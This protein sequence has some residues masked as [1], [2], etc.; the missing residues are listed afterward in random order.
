MDFLIKMKLLLLSKENIQL[1]KGEAEALLGKGKLIGNILL[2]NTEKKTGR[3]AY[4][5][6][7]CRV[8]FTANRKNIEKKIKRCKWSR[9]VKGSFALEFIK[10]NKKSNSL[11]RKYGGMVYDLLKAKSKPKVDLE[12]PGTKLVFA[13]IKNKIYACVEEF[14]N[15]EDFNARKSQNRPENLPISLS[16]KLARACV[17]LTGSNTSV[18]DPFCGIGGFLIEAGL[19]GLKAIGSDIDMKMTNASKRNLEF[20]KIKNFEIFQQDA[21]KINKKYCYIVTDLPYGRNARIIGDV[22]NKFL[23]NLKNI[24]KKRAVVMLNKKLNINAKAHFSVYIHKSLTKEIY[25][26]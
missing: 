13:E 15:K 4:T 3:L 2:I 14:E 12:N 22:Y 23:S 8:I 25:V 5:R 21:L 26:I 7:I 17:N 9:I 18:Y 10:N 16:P 20:Y 6:L 11:G 1:A 24:V 19:M